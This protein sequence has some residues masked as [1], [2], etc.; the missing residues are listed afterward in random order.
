MLALSACASAFGQSA[1]LPERGQFVVAPS[2]SYQSYDK[3]W[4]GKN[5]IA[6]VARQQTSSLGLE[7]GICPYLAA[8]FAIGY[9]WSESNSFPPPVHNNDDGLIDTSLGLRWR[10]ID[11][12]TSPCK[13][14][15][16]VTLRAG[17]IIAGTYHPNTAF[18]A[19]DGANGYEGSLL[20]GKAICPGFGLYGDI[21]Y[22][23]RDSHVPD[24]LFGSAGAYATWKSFTLSGGYRHVQSLTGLDLDDPRFNPRIQGRGFPQLKEENQSL[25]GSLGY[26]DKGGRYYQVFYAHTIDGRNT[27][28]KDVFGVSATFP[29][30]GK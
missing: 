21:G 23:V 22:R 16:T 24:D 18:S 28:Q 1:W 10:L 12:K 4:S 2:Y 30:G 27:G 19:G 8:D 9:S 14:A 20:L 5:K 6:A 25:E 17:G 11:E 15:P 3:Y 7:Y 29:L 26:T 13:F